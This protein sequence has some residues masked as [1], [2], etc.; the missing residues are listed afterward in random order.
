MKKS[1]LSIILFLML[2]MPF[3]I[4]AFASTFYENEI[5]TSEL[6]TGDRITFG[7]YP[8]SLVAD[9]N[10]TSKLDTIDIDMQSYGY[11]YYQIIDENN[12]YETAP[13]DMLYGDAS[14][15]GEV[16]RKVFIGSNRP[17]STIFGDYAA[18]SYQTATDYD[19][20][21]DYWFKWEP[22]VWRVL[23]NDNNEVYLLSESIL[24][25][26]AFDI[27]ITPQS[28]EKEF[29]L[30]EQC[31]LRKWL[32]DSFYNAAFTE[33]EKGIIMSSQIVNSSKGEDDFYYNGGNDTTDNVWIIS[34]SDAINSQYG[35]NSNDQEDDENRI[36]YGTDYAMSQGLDGDN[37]DDIGLSQWILRTARTENDEVCAVDEHGDCFGEYAFTNV[38]CSGVRPAIKIQ[39]NI[40]LKG[41]ESHC[42][43]FDANSKSDDSD[44][45]N[46]KT[47]K[48][49]HIT[50]Y[51]ILSVIAISIVVLIVIL[52]V[53]V[54]KKR[55]N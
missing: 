40:A 28:E 43:N 21:Y 13:V 34:Y 7:Y 53:L 46:L 48:I 20:G 16:Y 50:P 25:A 12:N 14:Y 10:L 26:Q 4:N 37:F 36:A 9:E 35:F 33:S 38:V 31:T 6:K 24:D 47:N 23:T 19:A 32:N 30:W 45:K 49:S 39:G 17:Y 15:K 54:K 18:Q 44:N 52:I 5:N 2:L 29:N 1:L 27:S 41:A 3:N 42:K 11:E 51:I 22:I 8:Q 55:N